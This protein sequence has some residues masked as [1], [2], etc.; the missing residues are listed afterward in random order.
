MKIKKLYYNVLFNHQINKL[1]VDSRNVRNNDI[2]YAINGE[3]VNG[4]DY[5]EEAIYNGAKTIVYQGKINKKHNLINYIKVNDVRKQLANDAKI[6]YRNISKKIKLVGVTGTNGKTTTTTLTYKY[7]RHIGYGACLIGSNGVYINE[8]HYVINNTTPSIIEI[9]EAL[10]R[11]YQDNIKIAIMEVSSHAIKMLRIYGLSFYA[12][13]L[14][15]VTQDH[16]DYHKTFLDYLYTKSMLLA[17]QNKNVI[18]NHDIKYFEFLNS[19][20]GCVPKTFGKNSNDYKIGKI[21]EKIEGT[22]FELTMHDKIYK[23]ETKML[24]KFNVYNIVGMIALIDSLNLFNDKIFEFLKKKISID[25]RMESVEYNNRIAIVDFAH[26]PDGVEKIL[27]FLNN[28]KEMN[29][30][31]VIGCGGNRDKLKRPIMGKLVTELSDFVIFTTDNPRDEK[32]EDIINDIILGCKKKNYSVVV[33]RKEAIHIALDIARCGDIVV[34]LGKGNEDYMI[35]GNEKIHFNDLE[36]INKYLLVK[37][38][39]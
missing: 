20:S 17:R 3:K 1:S 31:T 22:N 28:V 6:F 8:I 32:E 21:I 14:T 24:A 12:V 37:K 10:T 18:I 25:G 4:N 33:D 26:T 2:Y 38:N 7:L 36:E 35:K 16:L 11:A 29:I 34:I 5:I 13:L 30:I 23:V 27:T 19:I 39:G 15:N 9:Y